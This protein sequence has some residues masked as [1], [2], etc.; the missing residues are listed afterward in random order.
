MKEQLQSYLL[1]KDRDELGALAAGLAYDVNYGCYTRPGLELI[2]WPEIRERAQWI[3]FADLDKIHELNE[4]I[5]D[6]EVNRRIREAFGKMRKS[7]VISAGRWYSGDELVWILCRT[8]DRPAANPRQAARRLKAVFERFGLSATFGIARVLS[9][10][11]AENVEPASKL[12]K[13]SKKNGSR[14]T[15][16]QTGSLFYHKL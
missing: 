7:D 9:Y 8:D 11:L 3:I 2:V 14:G 10:E 13:R 15:V 5:G 6:E 4:S 12:V 16:C 1:S